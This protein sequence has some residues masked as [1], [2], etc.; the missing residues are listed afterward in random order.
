MK[1]KL[2]E[3][4]LVDFRKWQEGKAR[5]AR[6]EAERLERL[7]AEEVRKKR[8][9]YDRYRDLAIEM[10]D[11]WQNQAK[12]DPF[13]W[14]LIN[15]ASTQPKHRAYST[16]VEWL[17]DKAPG[18]YAEG[19]AICDLGYIHSKRLGP[20]APVSVRAEY[21]LTQIIR[22]PWSELVSSHT[23]LATRAYGADVISSPAK[24]REKLDEVLD[25]IEAGMR[26]GKRFRSER[27]H[28][29]CAGSVRD[30]LGR[31][32]RKT[33]TVQ[34]SILRDLLLRRWVNPNITPDI[35]AVGYNWEYLIEL[36]WI[37]R[38]GK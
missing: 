19:E 24:K 14:P 3:A 2:S 22:V 16:K 12:S 4:E 13:R 35:D 27:D 7:A 8:E 23:M 15:L 1:V 30:F 33:D 37:V 32:A 26:Y 5:Q 38:P 29:Q 36:S 9:R 25:Y 21:N 17:L 6:L 28:Y 10:G 20:T 31:E 34:F 18:T 11:V